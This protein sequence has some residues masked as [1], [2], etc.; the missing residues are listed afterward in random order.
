MA[1]KTSLGVARLI[2]SRCD[3]GARHYSK[4]R[5]HFLPSG[6][7][8]RVSCLSELM[9]TNKNNS[10]LNDSFGAFVSSNI[11]STVIA[12]GPIKSVQCD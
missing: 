8:G 9:F 6:P 12:R 1:L 4:V 3:S 2:N 10:K 11:L 5:L 7:G